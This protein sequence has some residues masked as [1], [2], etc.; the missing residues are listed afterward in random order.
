MALGIAIFHSHVGE[1]PASDPLLIR[2]IFNSLTW[3][4][5]YWYLGLAAC[6][7]PLALAHPRWLSRGRWLLLVLGGVLFLASM[8]TLIAH[9]EQFKV[10]A[11]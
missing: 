6:I 10:I 8:L 7:S 5:V 3:A 11:D 4:Q 9:V 1:P 2:T